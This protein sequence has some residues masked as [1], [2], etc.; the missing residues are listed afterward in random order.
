[1]TFWAAGGNWIYNYA[2]IPNGA[3]ST[4]VDNTSNLYMDA[5]VQ[6]SCTSTQAF[7]PTSTG[8]LNFWFYSSTDG[9]AFDKN[10]T[11]TAASF[12]VPN[13][14]LPSSFLRG[15][16]QYMLNNGTSINGVIPSVATFLGNVL[17]PYWGVLVDAYNASNNNSYYLHDWTM[18]YRGVYLTN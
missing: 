8:F 13:V 17:P 6:F 4:K 18:S 16:F 7:A 5:V 1:M 10:I 14:N 3:T 11:G 2:G 15:P 12:Q 9:I